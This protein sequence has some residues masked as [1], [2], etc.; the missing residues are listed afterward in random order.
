MNRPSNPR[1]KE[2][3]MRVILA[4]SVLL[5][6]VLPFWLFL[7]ELFD[8]HRQY[9]I[10]HTYQPVQATI[11]SSG[12]HR[13]SGSKTVSYWPEVQYQ[14]EV[15]GKTYRSEK[16]MAVH[17]SGGQ[18]W[19]QALAARFKKGSSCTAYCDPRDPNRAVILRRFTFQPYFYM[20]GMIFGVAGG[21]F[22]V[23]QL[24]GEQGA[25]A[26]R[27]ANGG[28]EIRPRL[29]G[30]QKLLT[31]KLCT[32]IWY[33]FGAIPIAHYFLFVPGP[34]R[35]G[36]VTIIGIFALLGLVPLAFLMRHLRMNR[37]LADATLLL[38]QPIAFCG[39]TFKFSISQPVLQPLEM[40]SVR[41]Q[42]RCVGTKVR[43]KSRSRRVLFEAVPVEL[44]HHALHAG[45]DMRLSGELTPPPDQPPSG[46]DPSRT[47]TRFD[48]SITLEC[49]VAHGPNY[50]AEFP[51]LVEPRPTQKPEPS[52][53]KPGAFVTVQPIDARYAGRILSKRNIIVGN[54][55]GFLPLLVL[56]AAMGMMALNYTAVFPD[57]NA[58]SPETRPPPP[59]AQVVF[60]IGAILA[61]SSAMF[62]IA[63]PNLLAGRFIASLATRII[64]NRTDATVR[65][66]DSSLLVDVIPRANWNRMM[67]ENATDLGFLAVDS[68]RREIRFE[69]DRERYRIPAEA[70]ISC[71]LEK[72]TLVSNASPDAPGVWLAVIRAW[73]PSGVWEAPIA[74]RL[75]NSLLLGGKIRK[76]AAEKV[77]A[78]IAALLL[79]STLYESKA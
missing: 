62:G 10:N 4:L 38:N 26:A 13:Y 66:A 36:P 75:A 43:G 71:E 69:G 23:L 79:H 55:I 35:G 24:W 32:A 1:A 2:N 49:H 76:Q 60:T 3:A 44:K 20:F 46:R 73:G 14:Y 8:A 50:I 22:L 67:F 27:P 65:P 40:R 5:M 70:I 21:T 72:S 34:H 57:K 48:W 19:A 12:I 42:F 47:F 30:A 53:S 28:F 16:L 74:P 63:F 33:G 59:K 61:A 9:V 39:Q 25:Q 54:L 68:R 15:A 56:L 64:A 29:G 17:V 58:P 51:L 41:V 37:R 77:Q 18:E 11:L 6:V 7:N 31:G 45:E 52:R 78:D